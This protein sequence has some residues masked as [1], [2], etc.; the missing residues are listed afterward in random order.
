VYEQAGIAARG[1][2][3]ELTIAMLSSS[4]GT[5]GAIE[6]REGGRALNPAILAAI[7]RN[8]FRDAP[9]A[10]RTLQRCRP[11]ICPF[12]KL[13]EYV[14]PGSS[15]LDIG[16]GAGLLLSLIAGLEVEF[17]G[18]GFDV[19]RRAID[20]ANIMRQR[21]AATFPKA[22]LS[23]LQVGRDSCW[24]SGVFDTVFIVDVMHHIPPGSQREFLHHGI[25]KVKPGGTLVYK[26]MCMRPWWKATANRLHDFV[27]ARERISYVPI[28]S[29]QRWASAQGM[30][31]I[32]R[33]DDTRLW[34]GHELCVFRRSAADLQAPD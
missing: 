25:S 13:V 6:N 8:L 34:Y 19:S 30:E 10:L 28:E 27:I 17:E 9:I 23:F 26:D 32:A 7:A 1:Q 14:R 11:Y 16:C 31:T 5:L 20:A 15:V 29:V 12:E 24:P 2:P 4:G 18:T 3:Q 22:K 21:A 33:R